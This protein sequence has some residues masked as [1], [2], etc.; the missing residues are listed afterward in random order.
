MTACAVNGT[1]TGSTRTLC[2]ASGPADFQRHLRSCDLRACGR[3]LR[4]LIVSSPTSHSDLCRQSEM[5]P[6]VLH[7][8]LQGWE[9]GCRSWRGHDRAMYLTDEAL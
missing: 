8:G 5:T 4:E 2:D 7:A 3:E 1:H 6:V 9:C